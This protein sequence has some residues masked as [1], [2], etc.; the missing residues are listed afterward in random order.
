MLKLEVSNH[1]LQRWRERVALYGD[2]KCDTL[3]D[4]VKYAIKL[5]GEPPIG[6]SHY[7]LNNLLFVIKTDQ[8]RSVIV[9]VVDETPKFPTKIEEPEVPLSKKKARTAYNPRDDEEIF[10]RFSDVI[11][12]RNWL[13]TEMKEVDETLSKKMRRE[14][15]LEKKKW[16]EA[17]L[18]EIKPAWAKVRWQV[19]CQKELQKREQQEHEEWQKWHN[20]QS[21]TN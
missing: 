4:T 12:Q 11:S 8:W 6:I 3:L 16:L 2:E 19:A 17:K 9:T 18:K 15:F 20:Q 10:S 7:R 1:A 21:S 5:Q 14:Y 13:I